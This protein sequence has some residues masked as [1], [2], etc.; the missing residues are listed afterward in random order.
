MGWEEEVH[1][2]RGSWV[3]FGR[4]DRV[5]S[6]KPFPSM[7]GRCETKRMNP[8]QFWLRSGS[9]PSSSTM[10]ATEIFTRLCLSLLRLPIT[11]KIKSH[12]KAS[13]RPRATS[14]LSTSGAHYMLF[15]IP[16]LRSPM[17]GVDPGLCAFGYTIVLALNAPSSACQAPGQTSERSAGVS[18][19]RPCS[20]HY[21]V[22][23]LY[24]SGLKLQ[25]IMFVV[26]C[27]SVCCPH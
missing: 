14:L 12:T 22:W 6:L 17:C 4:S 7:R 16:L 26:I 23:G 20:D 21:Q 13:L 18:F 19:V 24:I 27:Q 2:A 10:A 25:K 11:L 8:V 15:P 5:L 1:A 3:I 9:P